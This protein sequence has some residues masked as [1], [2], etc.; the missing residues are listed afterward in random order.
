MAAV[1]WANED[2]EINE[3]DGV[4]KVP[5][6]VAGSQESVKNH[7]RTKDSCKSEWLLHVTQLLYDA[8]EWDIQQHIASQRCTVAS[9]W[10]VYDQ[11]AS[12][13][14]KSSVAWPFV[15]WEIKDHMIWL[16]SK[17]NTKSNY[18]VI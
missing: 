1:A 5:T 17:N 13:H 3:E 10:M 9:L 18:G 4:L 2:V 8:T 11:P 12:N 15:T 7:H 6:P 16:N 14:N